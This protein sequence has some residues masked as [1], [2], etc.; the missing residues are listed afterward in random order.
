MMMLILFLFLFLV[1]FF[2]LG[3][4]KSSLSSIGP[5][6]SLSELLIKVES[7]A[8]P[9]FEFSHDLTNV[10]LEHESLYP[11]SNVDNA[12]ND[13]HIDDCL[14]N[15]ETVFNIYVGKLRDYYTDRFSKDT[16]SI[17]ETHQSNMDV[18]ESILKS[19]IQIY[20]NECSIAMQCAIPSI[21]KSDTLNLN[22]TRQEDRRQSKVKMSSKKIF[23][24]ANSRCANAVVSWDFEG[25]LQELKDDM[26]QE[27]KMGIVEYQAIFGEKGLIQSKIET[28]KK[29]G[30]T[31]QGRI[32]SILHKVTNSVVNTADKIPII[33]KIEI[34]I[35]RIHVLSNN[36]FRI[37]GLRKETD[38][39]TSDMS[40]A[41][42][43]RYMRMRKI[44]NYSK[45]IITQLL[46]FTV[47]WGQNEFQRRQSKIAA[48]RR[49]A[50]IPD[51]PLL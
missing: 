31:G 5:L 13:D 44:Q 8:L 40:V 38:C 30:S 41:Q 3:A 48:E 32:Y 49:L 36:I 9:L 28:I 35:D 20:F 14:L 29:N 24:N 15:S 11:E 46:L 1:C 33:N 42:I 2:E 51:L 22:K 47:N 23:L 39:D 10:L 27:L 17:F 7:S 43:K 6:L 50:D 12:V 18:A 45:W 16:K 34:V 37:I 4:S 19:R 25:T 21:A 26:E